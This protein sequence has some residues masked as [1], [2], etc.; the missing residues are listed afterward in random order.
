MYCPACI[1]DVTVKP[2]HNRSLLVWYRRPWLAKKKNMQKFGGSE[3][4]ITHRLT[5]LRYAPVFLSISTQRRSRKRRTQHTECSQLKHRIHIYIYIRNGTH[6]ST[7]HNRCTVSGNERY[8]K[9][10]LDSWKLVRV[11]YTR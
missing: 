8:S 1:I 5:T 10:Q 4:Q 9:S 2:N 6:G 7:V 3:K 11:F